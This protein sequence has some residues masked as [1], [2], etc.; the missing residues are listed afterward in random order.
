MV[1]EAKLAGAVGDDH[2]VL[3]QAMGPDAAPKGALGG[4]L[5]RIRMNA[6]PCM[7]ELADA[8]LVEMI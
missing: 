1:I 5:D 4:D 8:E 7:G 6:G 3:K 2:C